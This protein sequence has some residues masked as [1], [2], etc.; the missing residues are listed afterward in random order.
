[1]DGPGLTLALALAT[2]HLHTTQHKPRLDLASSPWNHGGPV[3]MN[4]ASDSLG[5]WPSTRM[6]VSELM[7][8]RG[9][10]SVTLTTVAV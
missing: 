9:R 2:L 7:T 8:G 6:A 4:A 3:A 10:V 5:S 1:M